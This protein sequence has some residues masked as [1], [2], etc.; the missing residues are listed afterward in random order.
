MRC[1]MPVRCPARPWLPGQCPLWAQGP[2]AADNNGEAIGGGRKKKQLRPRSQG[3]SPW[4]QRASSS[5]CLDLSQLI[6]ARGLVVLISQ[7]NDDAE[8]RTQRGKLI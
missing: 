2:L 1:E 3:L 6:C 7:G 8:I 5:P 4:T